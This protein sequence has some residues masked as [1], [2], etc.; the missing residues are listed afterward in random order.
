M[1]EVLKNKYKELFNDNSEGMYFS[2]GRINLI[3][4]HTD[5]NGGRVF[6][7]AITIGTYGVAGRRD[8][9]IVACYS[10]NFPNEGVIQFSLDDLINRKEDSWANY[11]KGMIK[12]LGEKGFLIQQGFN[13]VINGTI[14]N[15]SGLSSSASLE[16]LIGVVMENLFDLEI[17]RLELVKI[18]QIVEN[19]FIGVNSGIMDQFAIGMGKEGMAIYLDT[20]TL[21]YEWVPAVFDA[22]RILIMNTNKRRELIESNYNE[23]R[24]QCE[25]ALKKLQDEGISIESLGELSSEKFEIYR[26]LIQDSLL[27]KRAKHAVDENERTK[28][29]KEALIKGDLEEVGRLLNQSHVSLRDNYEVTGFELDTLVH[30]AWEQEG[31]LGARMTGAG[32]GGCAIA[33]IHQDSVEHAKEQI[34][35]TY[36]RLIGYPP[37]FY[38]AQI[39]DGAK[40]LE[41]K[42]KPELDC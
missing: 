41:G 22:Y 15:A 9:R 23:R 42:K 33:L 39:G 3:G 1:K 19:Q 13:L 31:V 21:S 11:I 36:E 18:G 2:P 7:A 29:A 25:K 5:Y 8:D 40:V 17:D 16:L 24:A 6:P 34:G 10:L 30:C 32:M 38:L 26:H 12:H 20:N 28:L 4:E 14:P 37:S 35:A 27:E